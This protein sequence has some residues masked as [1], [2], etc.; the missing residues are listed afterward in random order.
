MGNGGEMILVV[1]SM[2]SRCPRIILIMTNCWR[3]E[4]MLQ[5]VHL[6][7]VV[8][9]SVSLRFKLSEKSTTKNPVVCIHRLTGEGVK[10]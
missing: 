7:F 6:S 1:P 2:L 3:P 5:A 9:S 4:A 10:S 8:A